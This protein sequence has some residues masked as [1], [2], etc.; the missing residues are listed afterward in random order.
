MIK[1]PTWFFVV[2]VLWLTTSVLQAQQTPTVDVVYDPQVRTVLLY[3][4]IG[5]EP[6][7]P[8]LT[9]NPPVMSQDEGT[10]LQLE[11]DD[12]TGDYRSFRAKLIH[13]NADW[14]RSVLN[15][16]EFTYEYNDN[17]ITDYQVSV[18]TKIKYYHYRF[19]LPKVKLPGNYLLVVYDERNPRNIIFTRRFS[20]Y[21]NK[22]AVT[23]A[24]R[25]STDPA[26][27]YQDQQIDF[28]INYQGYQVISPQDDFK[29]IIRQ[30]YRDD[31]TLNRL[32]PT[33][34]RAFDQVVDYKLF[35]LTNTLP[36]GN[37]FRFFDTRTVLS[38][39]NYIDR[40]V[41]QAD[42]T[43]VYV[44]TNQPRSRQAY[45]QTDDFNG[46]FIIDQK[47]TSN[48]PTSA[49][50][51]ETIFT[52]RTN[53][54]PGGQVYVNGAFNLWLLND[55]NR[56]AFDAVTGAYWASILLKQGVY[57]YDYSVTGIPS[58]VT[59]TGQVLAGGNEFYLEGDYAQT[60]N[61]YEVF[62]Y[63]RPP[64]SRADE[65]VGYQRLSVNK[66]K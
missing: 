7:N 13:C 11:F 42:R 31:R 49:D 9:L 53:E 23:G 26:R 19:T 27:Q 52:L 35:D 6:V 3:P 59:R 56:M 36:G 65:L 43:T 39:A 28:S 44:Q 25:F 38:Q 40:I 57:N 15:D 16:I 33:N 55:R 22:V 5:T 8:A 30:N 2:S 47:E 51:I 60:E 4:V 64:A 61:D 10:A 24:V 48:G 62:V 29:V 20:P 12:L 21:S 50:Y 58:P 41:R 17:A 34:V 46:Q 18:N 54:I 63:H 14:Q 66:R 1:F 37:E 32:K 45:T